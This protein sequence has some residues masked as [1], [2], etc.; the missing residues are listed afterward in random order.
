MIDAKNEFYSYVG[1]F[2]IIT[3]VKGALPL[4]GFPLWGREGVTL[5]S[6]E[7]MNYDLYSVPALTHSSIVPIRDIAPHM[8]G[9]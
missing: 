6:L 2:V 8:S 1:D 4:G 5:P 7:K 9:T 3:G